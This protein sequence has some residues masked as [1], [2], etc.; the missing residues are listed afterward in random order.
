MSLIDWSGTWA[1]PE[2]GAVAAGAVVADFALD[3]SE[4]AG[5]A[6]AKSKAAPTHIF[7]YRIMFLLKVFREASPIRRIL[8]RAT[9]K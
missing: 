4:I 6:I 7:Q 5:N 8:N 1:P 3:S 2:A 9:G